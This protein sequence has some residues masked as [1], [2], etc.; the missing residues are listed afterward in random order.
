MSQ[1]LNLTPNNFQTA[2][3]KANSESQNYSADTYDSDLNSV[4][5]KLNSWRKNKKS[6]FDRIPE[7][8][9][10]LVFQLL[11]S[12]KYN[13]STIIKQLHISSNQLKSIKT[14]FNANSEQ[15]K[16]A[17]VPELLPF[18]L[19]PHTHKEQHLNSES[20]DKKSANKLF[21]AS[22]NHDLQNYNNS[23]LNQNYTTQYISINKA[24]GE[25][26]SIPHNLN[27]DLI[28]NIIELFLCSK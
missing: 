1:S 11:S 3:P 21:N 8:F 18:K 10:F 20:E 28:Y 24:T 23:K 6:K 16:N 5:A 4:A 13:K 17:E 15:R 25:N 14:Q 27:P 7:E 12:R 19:V 9:K 26:I 2:S 22:N